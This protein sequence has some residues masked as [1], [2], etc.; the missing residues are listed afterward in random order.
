MRENKG[1]K[2]L[3]E[4]QKGREREKGREKT[5]QENFFSSSLPVIKRSIWD[6]A[7]IFL[8]FTLLILAVRATVKN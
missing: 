7:K 2:N 1:E 6:K 5:K 3:L 4:Y 8:M